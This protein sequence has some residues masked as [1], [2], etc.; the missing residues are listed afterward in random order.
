MDGSSKFLVDEYVFLVDEYV[1]LIDEYVFLIDECV[2]RVQTVEYSTL[3]ISQ[4]YW[5]L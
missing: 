2:F 5:S 3:H 1:F 4:C